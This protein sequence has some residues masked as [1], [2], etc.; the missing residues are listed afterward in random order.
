M[1]GPVAQALLLACAG[2]AFLSGRDLTG[3]WPDSVVFKFSRSCD[4][5]VVDGDADRL[6]AP[7]PLAWFE[8]L[9]GV[10]G[11]HLHHAPRPRAPGQTL[12]VEERMMAGFVGGGP[13]WLIE[14]VGEGRSMLWQ[15]FD[16]LGDRNDPERK[17]W[18]NTY[19]RVGETE[20]QEYAAQPLAEACADLDHALLEIGAVAARMQ[21]GNWSD[22]FAA[23]RASLS[24]PGDHFF[25]RDFERYAGFGPV[26][27]GLLAAATGGS[28]FGGMGSWNDVG[29]CPELEADYNR[30]SEQLYTTLNNAIAALANST[31]RP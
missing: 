6:L 4:F 13:A 9:R 28:V 3:F 1:Q 11:L 14:V 7:D 26:Q 10:R 20:P 22:V 5:R 23:A 29:P 15:G 21:Y 27:Q 19:L 31:Y 30:T 18:L 8:T 2:N 16:R 25:Y 12:A 17:I 24:A